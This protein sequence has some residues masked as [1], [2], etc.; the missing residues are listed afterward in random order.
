MIIAKLLDIQIWQGK[1]WE[2]LQ[3]E[4]G[5]NTDTGEEHQKTCFQGLVNRGEAVWKSG[6]NITSQTEDQR[7]NATST[8][9]QLCDGQQMNFPEHQFFF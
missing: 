1:R 2:K 8:T 5:P 9:Y 4:N 7:L 3:N 6:T